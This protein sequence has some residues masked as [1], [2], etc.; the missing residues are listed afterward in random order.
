ME[1]RPQRVLTQVAVDSDVVD[2]LIGSEESAYFDDT[3]LEPRLERCERSIV[4]KRQSPQ[5]TLAT[6]QL[7]AEAPV[8]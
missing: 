1:H 6:R 5:S 2:I 7:S 8:P 4:G 3:T